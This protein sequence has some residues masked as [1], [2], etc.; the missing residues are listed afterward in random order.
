MRSG[1]LSSPARTRSS[2]LGELVGG[3]VCSTVLSLSQ[4]RVALSFGG[5]SAVHSFCYGI[6]L[7]K[8][9]AHAS[10]Y[11]LLNLTRFSHSTALLL[12]SAPTCGIAAMK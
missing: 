4:N 7:L 11:L 9:G 3:I 8:C 12:I 1:T 2:K 5:H 6:R 10:N